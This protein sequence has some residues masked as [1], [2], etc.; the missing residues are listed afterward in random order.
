M[1]KLLILFS[2]NL[3]N[4]ADI[5]EFDCTDLEPFFK[6]YVEQYDS[7]IDWRKAFKNIQQSTI[8]KYIEDYKMN[9]DFTGFERFRTGSNDKLVTVKI[10]NIVDDKSIKDSFRCIYAVAE[11]DKG[12]LKIKLI[13]LTHSAKWINMFHS[14]TTECEFQCPECLVKYLCVAPQVEFFHQYCIVTP[15]QE[16][17]PL[18]GNKLGVTIEIDE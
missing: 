4:C 3:I 11:D 9:I 17:Q 18:L 12:F 10:K 5:I 1:N 15:P 7:K 16:V 13:K 8:A 6:E 2:F 14:G